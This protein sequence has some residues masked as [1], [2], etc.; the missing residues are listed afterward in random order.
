L[1]VSGG[2]VSKS[3][4]WISHRSDLTSRLSNSALRSMP[5]QDSQIMPALIGLADQRQRRRDPVGCSIITPPSFP[6]SAYSD[7]ISH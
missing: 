6:P 2:Q 5:E 4:F 7:P 1:L 3:L